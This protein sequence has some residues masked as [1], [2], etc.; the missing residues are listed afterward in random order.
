MLNP[1]KKHKHTKK[2]NTNIT[3]IFFTGTQ[4]SRYKEE[5]PKADFIHFLYETVD[6]NSNI[7]IKFHNFRRFHIKNSS[8]ETDNVSHVLATT[9]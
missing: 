1:L 6:C 5:K 9:G 4:H 2:I 7:L 8:V 3:I